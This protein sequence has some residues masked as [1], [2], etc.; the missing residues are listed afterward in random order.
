MVGDWCGWFVKVVKRIFTMI[1]W[2]VVGVVVCES[3]EKGFY[4]DSVVG[5]WCGCFV[6]VVKGVFTMIVWLVIGVVGL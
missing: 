4:G 3:C 2:L 5:G 6:K 1:V